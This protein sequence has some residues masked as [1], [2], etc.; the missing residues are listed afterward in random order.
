MFLDQGKKYLR[1]RYKCE[2]YQFSHHHFS[3]TEFDHGDALKKLIETEK[4]LFSNNFPQVVLA[5]TASAMEANYCL[6]VNA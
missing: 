5:H 2:Y 1:T 4:D 3:F 6:I